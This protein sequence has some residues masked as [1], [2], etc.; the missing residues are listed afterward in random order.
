[1]TYAIT[2]ECISCQ[3]CLSACPTD[4]IQTNGLAFWI[5]VDRCNQC[6]GTHGVPQ[7]WAAC[8]TN[9]GCVPLTAG[10]TAVSLTSHSESSS[11]YWESWFATYAR[12]RARLMSSRQSS[13]WRQWFSTYSQTMR[14]LQTQCGDAPLMPTSH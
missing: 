9:E 2:N 10:V 12:L 1:M 14:N 3:R 11:D 8:P 5:E 4:A 13:Y 6:H 7:C